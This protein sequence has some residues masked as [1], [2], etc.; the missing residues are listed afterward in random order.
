MNAYVKAIKY[1]YSHGFQNDEE[2]KMLGKWTKVPAPIIKKAIPAYIAKDGR[3]NIPS[4]EEAY[5]WYVKKGYTK[6]KISIR[7]A[8]DHSFLK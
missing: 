6:V 2:V 8:V 7:D 3:V 1:H 4:L 5:R